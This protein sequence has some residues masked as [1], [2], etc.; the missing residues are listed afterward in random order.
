VNT[1]HLP[2][3]VAYLIEQL[4]PGGAERQLIELIKRLDPARFDPRLIT[5][6]GSGF[7]LDEARLLGIPFVTIRGRLGGGKLATLGAAREV[8]RYKP[9]IIHSYAFA[10]NVWA[11][12]AHLGARSS[13]F[14][15]GARGFSVSLTP[16]RQR[17][18]TIVHRMADHTISNSRAQ[19]TALINAGV[20]PA[21]ISVVPNGIDVSAFP[22]PPDR[23]AAK[24]GLGFAADNKVI[25]MIGSF[26]KRKRWD[27]F[28]RAAAIQAALSPLRI[29]CVG[30]GELQPEMELLADLLGIGGCTS[31]TGLRSDVPD[32]LAA[33]DVFVLSSDAEGQSN[34]VLEAMAMGIPVVATSVGGTAEVMTEGENGFLVP[35]GKPEALAERIG[36][37]LADA[38]LAQLMGVKGRARAETEFSLDECVQRT[39][40]IYRRLLSDKANPKRCYGTG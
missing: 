15:A 35:P 31:F 11:F 19:R 13:I 10:A 36:T 8:L 22:F 32:I 33:L 28:L 24:L 38:D 1:E 23:A 16:A 12:A 7:I 6:Y 21:R 40:A 14:I 9:H 2:V 3:R 30:E 4:A 29:V 20:N 18:D 39:T 37:L 26:T 5:G 25:G 17:A 34:V 27:V